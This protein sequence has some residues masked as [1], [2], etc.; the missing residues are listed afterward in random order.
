LTDT[1]GRSWLYP[2]LG[3]NLTD[4]PYFVLRQAR[5]AGKPERR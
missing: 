4:Q 1:S 3:A 5:A 2:G